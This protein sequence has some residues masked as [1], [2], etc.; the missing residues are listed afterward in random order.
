MACGSESRGSSLAVVIVAFCRAQAGSGR[1]LRPKG[2]SVAKPLDAAEHGSTMTAVG[3]TGS[4]PRGN[5][6][7]AAVL[8]VPFQL[9]L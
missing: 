6:R 9:T 3:G 2:R 7:F 4:S 8:A 5:R 1:D